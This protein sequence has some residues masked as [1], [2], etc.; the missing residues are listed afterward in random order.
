MPRS[1][2]I[3]FI[4]YREP[5]HPGDGKVL[6]G[7]TVKK[8]AIEW[9]GLCPFARCRIELS[10]MRDGLAYNKVEQVIPWERDDDF[11]PE[12]LQEP[13]KPA[14]DST[15]P[16]TGTKAQTIRDR[17]MVTMASDMVSSAMVC[18]GKGPRS[19]V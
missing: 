16:K 1:Q 14:R 8:E 6:A 13:P 11:R 12:Y 2:Y 3:Y 5:G 10:R 15:I 19:G 9:A 7:F 18:H 4:R 17:A